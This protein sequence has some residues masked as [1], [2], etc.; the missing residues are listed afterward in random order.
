MQLTLDSDTLIIKLSGFERLWSFHLSQSILVP[1]AH[2][3]QVST[4]QPQSDWFDLRAPGTA[5]PGVIKAGTYYTR[6]GREFWYVTRKADYLT[7]SLRDEYYKRIVL[8]L[9]N[10]AAWAEQIN[11]L[12][13]RTG[14]A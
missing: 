13:T 10:A 2:I 1:F 7:L 14:I 9:E 11:R 3:Q 4:T 5:L 8:S 12:I 6:N